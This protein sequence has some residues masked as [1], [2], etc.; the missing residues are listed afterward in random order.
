MLHVVAAIT[1]IFKVVSYFLC[2]IIIYLWMCAYPG[3]ALTIM[4]QYVIMT[5]SPI[6]YDTQQYSS[7]KIGVA[8]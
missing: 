4:I 3:F 8:S 5:Q 1:F 2:I 6:P 7:K